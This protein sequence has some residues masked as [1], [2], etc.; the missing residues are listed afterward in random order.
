MASKKTLQDVKRTKKATITPVKDEF[1]SY[2]YGFLNKKYDKMEYLKRFSNN[3][4]RIKKEKNSQ[5]FNP[6]EKKY[7]DDM[8]MTMDLTKDLSNISDKFL[9]ENMRNLLKSKK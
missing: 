1:Y 3:I 7:I 8:L 4:N 2:I 9:A 5:L 6:Y